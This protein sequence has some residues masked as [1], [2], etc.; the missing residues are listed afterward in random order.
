[1]DR[2][3]SPLRTNV[4]SGIIIMRRKNFIEKEQKPITR[5]CSL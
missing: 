5:L 1:M 3:T 2:K 4:F